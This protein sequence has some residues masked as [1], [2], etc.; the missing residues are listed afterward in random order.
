MHTRGRDLHQVTIGV[1]ASSL[2]VPFESAVCGS[3]SRILFDLQC[4]ATGQRN[5][6][7]EPVYLQRLVARMK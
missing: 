2:G 5:A 1:A 4:F 6:N 7:T 3:K